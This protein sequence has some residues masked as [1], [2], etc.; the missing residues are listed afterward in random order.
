MCFKRKRTLPVE[1]EYQEL[2]HTVITHFDG[3]RTFNGGL[4]NIDIQTLISLVFKRQGDKRWV[5]MSI[6]QPDVLIADPFYDCEYATNREL[7]AILS[8][9]M[10]AAKKWVAENSKVYRQLADAKDMKFIIP[11]K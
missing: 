2:V 9:D 7:Q 5:E 3:F 8:L 1:A 6:D 11:W 10:I 4:K